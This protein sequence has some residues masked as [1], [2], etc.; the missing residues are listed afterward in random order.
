MKIAYIILAYKNPTQVF[1]M[2]QEL[3]TKDSYFYLHVDENSEIIGFEKIPENINKD[4]LYYSK[5]RFKTSWSG[6]GCVDALLFN[7]RTILDSDKNYDFVITLTGQDYPIKSKA[8]INNFLTAHKENIFMQYFKLPNAAWKD[9]GI[10]RVMSYHFNIFK[11]RIA[12]K[13]FHRI[14][15]WLIP[16]LPQKDMGVK[17]DLY[18]GEAHFA[19]PLAAVKYMVNFIDQNPK[20]LSFFRHTYMPDEVIFQTLIMNSPLKNIVINNALKYIDWSK[21]KA[22]LPAVLKEEDFDKLS[23][24][25]ML[26][27]RKFDINIDN[28]VLDLIDNKL[29]K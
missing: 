15:I 8:F 1:R 20:F 6:F 29:I 17:Y 14:M 3:Q 12:I 28:T 18:G 21:P 9:G 10:K 27:A 2:I 16:I 4:C 26:F 5:K 7:M 25:E 23:N 13:I 19:F 22:G 11:K 24:S